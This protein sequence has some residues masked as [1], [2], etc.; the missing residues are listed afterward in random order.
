MQ[1]SLSSVP[2]SAGLIRLRGADPAKR[3]PYQPLGIEE[4]MTRVRALLRRAETQDGPRPGRFRT[5]H[6][7]GEGKAPASCSVTETG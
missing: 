4:L 6:L 7:D 1:Q 2:W 3:R 5:D